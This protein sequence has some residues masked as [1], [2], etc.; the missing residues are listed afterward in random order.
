MKGG[1][2]GDWKWGIGRREWEG[3]LNGVVKGRKVG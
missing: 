1:W 3:Y 2:G